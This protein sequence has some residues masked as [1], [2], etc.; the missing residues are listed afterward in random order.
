MQAEACPEVEPWCRAGLWPDRRLVSRAG[1]FPVGHLARA[2]L[3]TRA[4][5]L[6]A[7]GPVAG[8]GPGVKA[9]ASAVSSCWGALMKGTCFVWTLCDTDF[10]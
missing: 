1:S 3:L 7:A 9:V 10:K 5:A 6:T 4:G 8:A 2:G